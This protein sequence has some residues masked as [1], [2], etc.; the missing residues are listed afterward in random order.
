MESNIRPPFPARLHTASLSERSRTSG[1][2]F[3]GNLLH[4]RSGCGQLRDVKSV[5][6]CS[7][8][9]GSWE[10]SV[11]PKNVA[12]SN[13]VRRATHVTDFEI[14]PNLLPECGT[15]DSYHQ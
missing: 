2:Q 15:E 1:W 14:M 4:P 5:T 7:L 3:S 8:N 13:S 9:C 10:L 12:Y 11:D 6:D